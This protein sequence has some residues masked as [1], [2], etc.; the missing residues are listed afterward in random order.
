MEITTTTTS[1]APLAPDQLASLTSLAQALA[2]VND[3]REAS[4]RRYSLVSLLLLLTAGLLSPDPSLRAITRWGRLHAE[5]VSIP[6]GFIQG[7][8]PCCATLH[9]VLARLEAGELGQCLTS[10]LRSTTPLASGEGIGIDG[11]G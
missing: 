4:G 10:W 5:A 7:R 11:R 2:E 1:Q 9:R 8:M 6:L 3:P